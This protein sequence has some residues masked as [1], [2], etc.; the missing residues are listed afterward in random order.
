[1]ST[2]DSVQPSPVVRR[3]WKKGPCIDLSAYIPDHPSPFIRRTA[4]MPW[5][6]HV[7]D[8]LEVIEGVVGDAARMRLSRVVKDSPDFGTEQEMRVFEGEAGSKYHC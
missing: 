5:L 4:E 7:F 6:V 1:M 2:S 3:N 8:L